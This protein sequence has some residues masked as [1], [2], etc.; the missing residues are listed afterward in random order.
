M[1]GY[2]LQYE[3]NSES[4]Q[5]VFVVSKGSEEISNV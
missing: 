3:H 4:E 5:F 2:L 1:L